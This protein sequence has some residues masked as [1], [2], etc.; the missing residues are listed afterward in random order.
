MG[1]AITGMLFLSSV[2]AD[3][4]S[5]AER[6]VAAHYEAQ[7]LRNDRRL[8]EARATLLQCT[9]PSCPS[10]VRKECAELLEEVQKRQ[11]TVVFTAKDAAGEDYLDVA[12]AVD[13]RRV[14]DRLDGRAVAVDAGPH[15]LVF[16]HSRGQSVEQTILVNEGE[17]DRIVRAVFPNANT[18]VPRA[19][20]AEPNGPE[21]Q[22]LPPRVAL[23]SPEQATGTRQW[24]PI[25]VLG[26]L[27]ILAL[28][29]FGYFGI[30]GQNTK[31]RLEDT[32]RSSGTCSAREVTGA[33]A[34]LII[35][36]ISLAVALVSAATGIYLFLQ[37]P[38]R[39]A[40]R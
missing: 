36:D 27:S 16:Q 11:P 2:T 26:G 33:R 1:I 32:C 5:E 25:V 8:I 40:T 31:E 30:S 24:A 6:C 34:Q 4:S 10:L 17:K 13:G 19:A 38:T 29:S 15:T 37:H 12:V 3:A 20:A 18:A 39:T 28:S 22:P 21:R 14:T 23:L 7:Q 9:S 35:A